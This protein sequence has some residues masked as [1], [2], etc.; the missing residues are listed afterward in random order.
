MLGGLAVLVI[1]GFFA[2]LCL[3]GKDCRQRVWWLALVGAATIFIGG[4]P[5]GMAA[6]YFKYGKIWVWDFTDIKTLGILAYWL[7]V[8]GVTWKCGRRDGSDSPRGKRLAWLTLIGVAGTVA[9]YLIP[10]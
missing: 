2:A 5:L 8:L 1:A 4:I 9:L 6:A 10:H 3:L 7:V